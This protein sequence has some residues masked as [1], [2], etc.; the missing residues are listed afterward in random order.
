MATER[1]LQRW[2]RVIEN[3]QKQQLDYLFLDEI[4]KNVA[5]KNYDARSR[6][7]R[8]SS[9]CST[10]ITLKKEVLKKEV[11]LVDEVDEM[12]QLRQKFLRF[13][14]E[15]VGCYSDREDL[16]PQEEDSEE[17]SDEDDEDSASS[18]GQRED[19]DDGDVEL[20]CPSVLDNRDDHPAV[21]NI[22][23]RSAISDE[24]DTDIDHEDEEENHEG[25][26]GGK[27]LE[28]DCGGAAEGSQGPFSTVDRRRKNA[29]EHQM[30]S[31]V[32]AERKTTGLLSAN[33]LAP[34]QEQDNILKMQRKLPP[35][36]FLG[37]RQ[38]SDRDE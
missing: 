34:E 11:L 27:V 9:P 8:S 33:P 21:S 2:R 15:Q 30:G 28:D 26:L 32:L 7:F 36:A 13:D 6:G 24:D 16:A 4:F 3:R 12:A 5:N 35:E 17:D 23:H 1:D 18:D 22:Y 31:R 14:L 29:A 37:Q 20:P 19:D 38:T 25:L 10:S